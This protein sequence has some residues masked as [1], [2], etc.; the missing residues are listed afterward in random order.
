MHQ[1]LLYTGKTPT[2]LIYVS[3]TNL[4][5]DFVPVMHS[6]L[7]TEI[8]FVTEG[9]GYL[10][11]NDKKYRLNKGDGVIIRGSVMHREERDENRNMEFYAVGVSD[12]GFSGSDDGI[13]AFTAFVSDSKT[14]AVLFSA[15]MDE[16]KRAAPLWETVA[17]SYVNVITALASRYTGAQKGVKEVYGTGLTACAKRIIE[18]KF[19][20]PVKAEDV[21]AVLSVSYSTLIHTFKRETGMT[22][23]D[24]KTL[25]RINEAKSLLTLT[26]MSINQIALNVGFGT[27]TYFTKTFREN[28]GLTPKQYRDRA[29]TNKG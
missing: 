7:N 10:I 6:H 13:K 21:A 5:K 29:E 15:L 17:A 20:S 4:E 8:L 1:R 23:T 2:E 9:C 28:V 27:N 25:C 16:M 11:G 26:D 3:K 18:S 12:F 19:Y 24:Y 14:L 22:I